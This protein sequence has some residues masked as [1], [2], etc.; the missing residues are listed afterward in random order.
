[1]HWTDTIVKKII[2][3][4]GD[5]DK[6][7]IAAGITPSG[8][9]HIGN[10]REIITVDLVKRA[11]KSAGKKVRFIYSWDEYDV[12][13][14]VPKNM[15][16]KEMLK[17]HLRMPVVDVPDP[18]GKEESYARH[19]QVEVEEDVVRV[20][21]KPE[22]I[23]Q[24]KMYKSCKYVEGIKTALQ[25]TEKI[26]KYL[27][28]YRK[29][30]L[31]DD[32][33][34]MNG[35]CPKC[36]KDVVKFYDYDGE[37]GLKMNCECGENQDIDIRK[38]P[39]VKLRWRIDWPMRWEYE[40]VDFEPAG[41]EHYA[42]P[43]GSRITANEMVEDI[44]NFEHPVDLKYDFITIKGTG[45]KMSSSLG[46]VITLRNCLEVYEPEIIRWLFA[47]TRPGTEF[48]ISFDLDVLR[49]YE[50]FDKCERIYFKAQEAK[51]EKDFETQK[52]NYE[53]SVVDK[54][55][56]KMPLQPG[57]RHLTTLIQIYEGDIDKVVEEI[58]DQERVRVRA[59]CAKNWIEK[60]APDDMK[61]KIVKKSK[62][63]DK[64]VV[65]KV[66]ELVDDKISEKDLHEQIYTI[67]KG[68][69]YEP[70][71]FFKMF[72]QMLIKKDKGPKLAS[73][74]LIIGRKRLENIFRE[75]F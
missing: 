4:K 2:A 19:F 43:G 68:A 1:M 61:F 57:F 64:D 16:K 51:N 62:V 15:P 36:G 10:F 73:F 69:N 24:A 48:A 25:K 18:F 5:K 28:K 17:K 60:Y 14:K 29:E 47:G 52:R 30:E 12:F 75:V 55:P 39:F 31:P 6:Y 56:K 42:N 21:I 23:Y 45:G 20:G 41:K 11:L 65:R 33:L 53:L 37:Y 3:I 50:D 26:K 74:L 27:N 13:R 32:W 9:V 46:N 67:C 54:V 44:Y 38:A 58:G 40:Q 59:E 66:V 34:P 49:I 35:F 72:Y 70:K 7:V 8:T 22:F 71:D 63:K